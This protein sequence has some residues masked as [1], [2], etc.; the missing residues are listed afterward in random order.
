MIRFTKTVPVE[1]LGQIYQ[2]PVATADRLLDAREISWHLSRQCFVAA[3]AA[4]TQMRDHAIRLALAI[5]MIPA[6]A[7]AQPALVL[8]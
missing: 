8:A 1:Q 4:A 2:L 6:D 5:P 3:P 7:L